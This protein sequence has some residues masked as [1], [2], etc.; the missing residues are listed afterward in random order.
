MN[1]L[2]LD[3]DL[4]LVVLGGVLTLAVL[5]DALARRQAN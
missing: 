3:P 2:G 5:F 4:Q 1:L